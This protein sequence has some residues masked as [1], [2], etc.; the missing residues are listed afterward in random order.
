MS[1][2]VYVCTQIYRYVG[3]HACLSV[4]VRGRAGGTGCGRHMYACWLCGSRLP[5]RLSRGLGVWAAW[6]FAVGFGE[7]GGEVPRWHLGT[8]PSF[9][10]PKLK[11][12]TPRIQHPESPSLSRTCTATHAAH[13]FWP[14]ACPLD[15]SFRARS[16]SDHACSN[17]WNSCK[18]MTP[19]STSRGSCAAGEA[20]DDVAF[21]TP[22]SATLATDADGVA[23]RGPPG[24]SANTSSN[25]GF[26]TVDAVATD[27][28]G[29]TLAFGRAAVIGCISED[30]VA[31]VLPLLA[32]GRATVSG[33]IWQARAGALDEGQGAAALDRAPLIL[34]GSDMAGVRGHSDLVATSDHLF[35][36]QT[37]YGLYSF[38][39][40]DIYILR[41]RM[42]GFRVPELPWLGALRGSGF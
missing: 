19:S 9:V 13:R 6:V 1:R 15:L 10:M 27:A 14:V 24:I 37:C 32:F 20:D 38:L 22:A 18:S 23:R 26:A 42:Q 12:Q 4:S 34:T 31:T 29:T 3:V 11:P 5:S 8:Q 7:G 28:T 35:F 16:H 40:I 21:A 30:A 39:W 33:L 25:P 2:S 36:F 17:L 41:P